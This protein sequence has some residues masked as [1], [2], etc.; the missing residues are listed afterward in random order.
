M[1]YW[2]Y[3]VVRFGRASD[4]LAMFSQYNYILHIYAH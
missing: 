3:L 1:D 2:L 4:S